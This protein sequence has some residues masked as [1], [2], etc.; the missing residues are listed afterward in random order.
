MAQHTVRN[1]I[2]IIFFL[3]VLSGEGLPNP[4]AIDEMVGKGAPNFSLKDLNGKEVSLVDL[5]GKVILLNF[6]ATWCPPCINEIPKLNELKKR[7]A[8]KNFEILGVSTDGSLST[9][10]KF[11]KKHPIAY[12]V[13][14][15]RGIKA[16]RKYNVFSL[17]TTFLIDKNGKIVEKFLGEYNWT[18]PEI[19]KKIDELL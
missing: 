10:R 7:Y 19:R 13:L 3:I 5:R 6:W 2:M 12:T 9:V 15:D 16:S 1:T 17:P 11:L 4:W 14:H 18:S 8:E